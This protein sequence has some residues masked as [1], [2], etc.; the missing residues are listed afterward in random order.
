VWHTAKSTL[1][2]RA[3]NFCKCRELDKIT[4]LNAGKNSVCPSKAWQI[5]QRNILHRLSIDYNTLYLNKYECTMDQELTEWWQMFRFH[6]LGGSTALSCVKWS[7]GRH[8]E[9]TTSNKNLNVSHYTKSIL[10][11]PRYFC[12]HEIFAQHFPVWN[13]IKIKKNHSQFT[14]IYLKNTPAKFH[15]DTI[16]NDG[17]FGCF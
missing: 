2:L 9:I 4:K 17:A 3:W 6:S 13:D 14:H 10:Q 15:S 11:S 7:H 8:Y 16:W 12:V 5:R 1:F